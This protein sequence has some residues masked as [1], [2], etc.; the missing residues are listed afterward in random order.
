[1]VPGIML[2][3]GTSSSTTVQ[4]A[5]ASAAPLKPVANPAAVPQTA[6]QFDTSKTPLERTWRGD[7]DGRVRYEGYP[8]FND[9]VLVSPEGFVTEHGAQ[10]PI[11]QAGFNIHSAIHRARPDCHAAAHCHSLYGKAWSVFGKKIDILTQDACLFHNNQA[12][13]ENFGGIVLAAEEGEE[14]AQALGPKNKTAILQNHGL[15]TVGETVDEAVY[16]FSA[17]ERMCQAQLL[18]EAALGGG[19]LTKKVIGDAEAAWTAATLQYPENVYA[20]A[21]TEFDLLRLERG[22]FFLQ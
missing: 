3:N 18:I 20:N 16:L 13:Y 12:V 15:L 5:E 11:N 10:R 19:N 14:I 2:N 9:L 17:L 4:Q 1:M 21:Q 6:R 7:V 22:H 8:K